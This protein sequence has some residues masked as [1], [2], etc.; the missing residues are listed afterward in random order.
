MLN[1]GMIYTFV[2][3]GSDYNLSTSS[4]FSPEHG[5]YNVN[6]VN[7]GSL[8]LLRNEIFEFPFYNLVQ[9]TP[10][11]VLIY[12]E[13]FTKLG[14]TL[15]FDKEMANTWITRARL[16]DAYIHIGGTVEP[17][18]SYDRC[19][20]ND[21]FYVSDHGVDYLFFDRYINLDSLTPSSVN[22]ADY[23]IH[24][25]I[26]FKKTNS[27]YYSISPATSF[28]KI[29]QAKSLTPFYDR[30][31]GYK[32][33]RIEIYDLAAGINGLPVYQLYNGKQI[34]NIIPSKFNLDVW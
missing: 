31:D 15:Y 26:I 4:T 10:F 20:V 14:S 9:N 33:Y 2:R 19:Y 28:E 23:L 29:I 13:P 8:S 17:R 5:I 12:N 34:P 30:G 7:I 11:R 16:Y 32:V 25:P 21:V 1:S 6:S 24:Y 27:G 22:D 18:I 3:N